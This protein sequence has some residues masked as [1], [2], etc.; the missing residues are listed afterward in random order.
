MVAIFLFYVFNIVPGVLSAGM[1]RYKIYLLNGNDFMMS[2]L[3]KT[4]G[5]KVSF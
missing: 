1:Q 3:E 2:R 5:L 4:G